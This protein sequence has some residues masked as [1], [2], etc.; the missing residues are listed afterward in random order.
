[1]S[2]Q[3]DVLSDVF[4]HKEQ[5]VKFLLLFFL[6]FLTLFLVSFIRHFFWHK[7]APIVIQYIILSNNWGAVQ[8][9]SRP[10]FSLSSRTPAMSRLYHGENCGC[11]A[12]SGT[13]AY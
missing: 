6:K 3:S 2:V 13:D 8:W 9:F 11:G 10:P 4:S 1:M 7:N 5:R 12:H